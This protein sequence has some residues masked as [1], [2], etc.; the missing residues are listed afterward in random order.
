MATTAPESSE[1]PNWEA[2]KENVL[3]VKKGRSAKGLSMKLAENNS[4]MD[5]KAR[6]QAF[7]DLLDAAKSPKEC[8]QSYIKYIKWI[9]EEYPSNSDKT[10]QLLERCT[11]EL[12]SEAELKNDGDF[13]KVWVEYVSSATVLI[14][15]GKG[16]GKKNLRVP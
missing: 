16:W 11:V 2:L 13:I 3:P 4:K 7:E 14:C 9:R 10:L 8:L 15:S 6:E 12:K 5:N 1:T